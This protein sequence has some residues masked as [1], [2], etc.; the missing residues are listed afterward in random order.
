MEKRNSLHIAVSDTCNNSC[1]FCLNSRVNGKIDGK[2]NRDFDWDEIKN[3]IDKGYYQSELREL[4][5]TIA[6]PTLGPHLVDA[7]DY[8]KNLGYSWISMNTNGRRLYQNNLIEKLLHAGL[9]QI[10]LSI[11]GPNSDIHDTLV[12]RKG[13]FAEI[14]KGLEIMKTLRSAYNFRLNFLY[15]ITSVNLPCIEEM[16][17]FFLKYSSPDDGEV[18]SY[19]CLKALG[20][21]ADTFAKY[22]LKYG[23]IADEWLRVWREL[24]SPS[25]M[26]LCEIPGCVLLDELR[27]G[28]ALPPIDIPDRRYIS[29]EN[30]EVKHFTDY[31]Y[32]KR[33][34]CDKCILNPVCSG[35]LKNYIKLFDWSE[36]QPVLKLPLHMR[37]NTGDISD[38]E[39]IL[40]NAERVA[41]S[42]LG[43]PYERRNKAPFKVIGLFHMKDSLIIK[44]LYRDS[45]KIEINISAWDESKPSFTNTS[46]LSFSYFGNDA[47]PIL[48]KLF[49]NLTKRL[50]SWSFEKLVNFVNRYTANTKNAESI[51]NVRYEN[52]DFQFVRASTQESLA[53][54]SSDVVADVRD[55]DDREID[56]NDGIH[57]SWGDDNRWRIF[58]AHSELKRG[59]DGIINIKT[60]CIHI[61][62]GDIECQYVGV[63]DFV[64]F[65]WKASKNNPESDRHGNGAEDPTGLQ[66]SNSFENSA[67]YH[68][69]LEDMDIITGGNEKL[70][71]LFE[72]IK[73]ERAPE[74]VSLNC[75]CVPMIIGD[76]IDFYVDEA[77]KQADYPILYKSQ[78]SEHDPFGPYMEII[79]TR[80]KNT[81]PGKER[82]A[83]INLVGF[84]PGKSLQEIT[85]LIRSI[86]LN[87]NVCLLPEIT[88]PMIDEYR[89]AELQ[90]LYPYKEWSYLFDYLLNDLE[91]DT[92]TPPP[93]R[94]ASRQ[95]LH[96]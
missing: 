54:N 80:L 32:C 17:K 33:D 42:I 46:H 95:R 93:H 21:A 78:D 88:L 60:P 56:A 45:Q 84:K 89:N 59:R 81:T 14:A 91:I 74:L 30:S 66:D 4:Q 7:V 79:V 8:A 68:T 18:L 10:E 12:Q 72:S 70:A 76:D 37:H 52:R 2:T 31:N 23:E 64:S 55:A 65:P 69:N 22:G 43:I 51:P 48:D 86:G 67:C 58:F 85:R 25:G 90:V 83:R 1:V 16:F 19:T 63:G 96:G 15:V 94:M 24:N 9:N 29:S 40:G 82:R 3:A 41:Y 34:E 44:L 75:T 71:L 26:L 61:E 35:V 20:L 57:E 39:S 49:H 62:H 53:G 13:A 28:E 87:I 11:H 47:F 5:I 73:D 50:K 36:F 27:A 6:E 77:R 92:I 38:E